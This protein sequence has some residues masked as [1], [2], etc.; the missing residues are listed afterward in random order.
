MYPMEIFLLGAASPNN[1]LVLS[2]GLR[3]HDKAA[4]AYLL[5]KVGLYVLSN[6]WL[7]KATAEDAEEITNDAVLLLLQKIKQRKFQ[8]RGYSPVGYCKVVVQN[9]LRNFSRKKQ[10]PTEL[11][12]FL[13]SRLRVKVTK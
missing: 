1:P 4:I 12:H 6:I 3:R 10:L 7:V 9:L 5:Q 8:F 11:L 13:K 2:E